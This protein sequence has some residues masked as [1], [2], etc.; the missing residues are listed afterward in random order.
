MERPKVENNQLHS[1]P[2]PSFS[3]PPNNYSQQFLL[4][5]Q[6]HLQE[7]IQLCQHLDSSAVRPRDTH[8]F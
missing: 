5:A 6:G 1:P 7:G 2:P 4:V 3:F 8:V